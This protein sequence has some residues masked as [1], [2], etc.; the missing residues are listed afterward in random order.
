M[1]ELPFELTSVK[2]H[3]IRARLDIGEDAMFN[4]VRY[5]RGEN[6]LDAEKNQ[7]AFEAKGFHSIKKALISA[8]GKRAYTALGL[9]ASQLDELAWAQTVYKD[10]AAARDYLREKGFDE[11][12]IEAVLLTSFDTFGNLSLMAMRKMIPHLE[13][14]RRYDEAA[15]E[16]GYHHSNLSAG[17]EG[18]TYLPKPD[19]DEILNPVVYRAVN[20]AV[21]MINA[22]IQ[23]YGAPTAIHIELGTDLSRTLDERREEEK[24]IERNRKVNETDRAQ[25]LENFGQEPR[26]QDYR[27]WRFYREQQG[28]CAYCQQPL[29][30]SRLPEA[31][32]VEIDHILPWSR[33]FDDSLV[34]KVLVHAGCNRNKGNRTPFEMYGSDED[35]EAWRLLEAWA[36]ATVSLPRAKRDRLLR[37]EFG[38]ETASEFRDRHLNDTR[39]IARY[40]KKHVE[41][42]LKNGSGDG[43]MRAVVVSG[44][45]THFMRARWGLTKVRSESDLHHALDAAVVACCGRNMVQRVARWHKCK[46]LKD[47]NGPVIDDGTGE[48]LNSD[49]V[50]AA[51]A[52]FPL[53][54]P[55]FR[56]ELLGRLDS[57]PEQYLERLPGYTEKHGPVRP[58]RVSRA[59]R[60]KGSGM[61]HKDKIRSL[62]PHLQQENE[63]RQASLKVKLSELNLKKLETMSGYNDPR[64]AALVQAIRERLED[65]GGDGEKAFADSQPPLYMPAG[66]KCTTRNRP[67]VRTV[68]LVESQQ[69]G[70]PV[71]GGIA[72]N[73]DMPRIDIFTDRKKY[74]VVPVYV[75]DQ[76]ELPNRA[77]ASGKPETEWEVMG[78]GH[79]FLFSLYRDSYMRI[80]LK[81]KVWEGYF[82]GFDRSTGAI[83][84]AAHDRSSEFGKDGLKRS[85]GIKTAVNL[86]KFHVDPLGRLSPVNA[87]RRKPLPL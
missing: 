42:H 56:H 1:A 14:G 28:R 4:L 15:I 84:L 49:E 33:S 34:N 48:L 43:L 57:N 19:S 29:D 22:A 62:A 85:I 13:A 27:K 63:V 79:A 51:E 73:G 10:D 64:N 3:Q 6:P 32:Y 40:L 55:D 53:P 65:F 59:P 2:W 77:V 39:Y 23:Y 74:F 46:E 24:R 7:L 5:P 37:R 60:I 68:K 31:N 44:R 17:G 9:N 8:L 70:L 52:R 26:G 47:Y 80:T 12:V 35:S 38:K 11:D 71:R 76:G 20:Q 30:E 75:K 82:A 16:A 87:E 66:K 36:S 83:H 21:R 45:M 18:A 67:I 86:E 25:Y 78:E 41:T 54:W 50:R 58:V 69:S 61:V 72:S 81:S